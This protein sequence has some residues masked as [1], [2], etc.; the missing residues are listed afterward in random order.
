MSDKCEEFKWLL[1][2]TVTIQSMYVYRVFRQTFK[3]DSLLIL[4]TGIMRPSMKRTS[5]KSFS[6][7]TTKV[8][9]L[10]YKNY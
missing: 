6:T 7:P 2:Q 1:R 5:I 9:T 3:T 4:P 10:L 8:T